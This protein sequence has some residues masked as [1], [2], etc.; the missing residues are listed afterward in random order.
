MISSDGAGSSVA[1]GAGRVPAYG[2]DYDPHHQSLARFPGTGQTGSYP[3]RIR[4]EI[5]HT[6]TPKAGI[7]G[8][9]AALIA[10]CPTACIR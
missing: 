3:R 10:G 2:G 8:M 7:I 6:H 9:L 1:R 5:V 4:P